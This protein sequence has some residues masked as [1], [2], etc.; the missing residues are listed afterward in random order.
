MEAIHDESVR[1]VVLMWA[2][3]TGKTE[4]V[5]NV[6]GFFMDAEPAP[7]LV[8]QPT[9]E[10]AEDWSKERLVPM[11]RDCPTL[12]GKVSSP[13]SRDSG[14]TILTKSFP[15]GS[16][17]IAGANAPSG[18][19]ARP[20]RVVIMDEVDRFPPSAGTEG[21]PCA[22]AER[23]TESFWNAVI[24][25]TS[26]PTIKGISRIEK[27]YLGTDQR[28]WHCQCPK[29]GGWDWLRWSNVRWPEGKP[30][31]AAYICGLCSAQLDDSDRIEMVRNGEWRPTAPFRGHRGY[32][33][34]GINSLFRHKRGFKNRLHQM[35]VEFLEAKRNGAQT[36][37]TWINTFL[38]ETYEEE[39]EKVE[40]SDLVKRRQSYTKLP[41]TVTLITCGADVQTD[42]VEME[43]VGWGPGEES[44]G[45][46]YVVIPGRYDD[47]VLWQKVREQLEQRFE[48]ED[49]V[50]LGV[51]AGIIDSSGFQDHVLKFTKPMFPRNIIGGKGENQPN[52]PIVSVISRNN[53]LRAPQLR[54]GTDTAKAIIM[55]RLRQTESGI[56]A[57]HFTDDPKAGFNEHYFSML[58]AEACQVSFKNG[59]AIRKWIVMGNRRNEAL[60][61]RVYAYAALLYLNPNWAKVEKSIAK[62]VETAT[63]K[64]EMPPEAT[65]EQPKPEAPKPLRRPPRRHFVN[66]WRRY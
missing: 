31:E 12:R 35:A 13:R 58:T 57:M 14:N 17:A 40:G 47:P 53:K 26:T 65:P 27:E 16:I 50:M 8:V 2:S 34:N 36:L 25:K 33:L 37:K 18:L 10:R 46:R 44:W 43:F 19:A 22:L 3:Q 1:S 9:I 5:N 55:S 45:V 59:V 61:C 20:R 42:R 56:G 51:A 52:K 30:E 41:T 39:A 60:D 49:G 63:L 11:I 32:H 24:L 21:D 29:C 64:P 62:R 6:V 28:K 66:S 4:T 54:I 38:A 15:G 23:R 7:I 48:R